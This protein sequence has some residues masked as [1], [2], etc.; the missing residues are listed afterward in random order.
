MGLVN[1]PVAENLEE[2]LIV[3]REVIVIMSFG[4]DGPRSETEAILNFQRIKYIIEKRQYLTETQIN[5]AQG[6]KFEYS[7]DVC[8]SLVGQIPEEAISRIAEADI[9]IAMI[10]D[11]NV[12]VIFEL[13]IRNLMKEETLLILE[14]DPTEVLPIYLQSMAY[15]RYD[16]E[17][18]R[19][20][21]QI[22]QGIAKNRSNYDIGWSN[23][24]EIPD[25]LKSAIK[26]KDNS[27]IRNL[28]K[29]MFKL[30]TNP[31]RAPA[32]LR[33]FVNNLSPKNMLASWK[34]FAPYSVVRI[35]WKGRIGRE[36]TSENLI[37]NPVICNANND[38]L[39]LFDLHEIPDPDGTQPLTSQSLVERI[40]PF[41]DPV[42]LKR[43]I[44]DQASLFEKIVFEGRHYA[45]N[46]PLQFNECHRYYG[47]Q[48]ML[49]SLIAKQIVGEATKP[50][51]TFLLVVYIED[52]WPIG[53]QQ[54]AA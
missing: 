31:P 5:N 8:Y 39:R 54:E 6:L 40:R 26:E 42:D 53:Y 29:A 14:G 23:L 38:F 46:I 24:E 35:R 37:G 36:Y 12:N 28:S 27:L 20:V 7:V 10:T 32:Y 9:L 30:E 15:I 25:E 45:A 47:N 34:T 21:R 17:N 1:E 43:F 33:K 48:I 22:I 18:F 11:V 16:N 52:F 51:T 44:D 49:P 13:A 19:P 3:R 41:I 2:E 50:H 4:S